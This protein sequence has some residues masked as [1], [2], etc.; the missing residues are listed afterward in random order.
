[1][2]SS[3][4]AL[5]AAGP[6]SRLQFTQFIEDR[7]TPVVD[8]AVHVVP[9]A[10]IN[11]TCRDLLN[12]LAAPFRVKQVWTG[13]SISQAL[14]RAEGQLV[15]QKGHRLLRTDA[16]GS[17]RLSCPTANCLVFAASTSAGRIAAG[18][19]VVWSFLQ[20][21][22]RSR[23]L[24][25]SAG[26]SVVT[27]PPAADPGARELR[28]IAAAALA[29]TLL[30][31]VLLL[32]VLHERRQMRRRSEELLS[33]LRAEAKFEIATLNVAVEAI[34]SIL[35]VIKQGGV[36]GPAV[37]PMLHGTEGEASDQLPSNQQQTETDAVVTPL[38][39][40]ESPTVAAGEITTLLE[41]EQAAMEARR[42]R[43]ALDQSAELFQQALAIQPQAEQVADR[44]E[45]A[46]D[47]ATSLLPI[48]ENRLMELRA[49][50]RSEPSPQVAMEPLPPAVTEG[51]MGSEPPRSDQAE[52][53]KG[54]RL[55]QVLPIA[56]PERNSS[57]D[58]PPS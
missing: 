25:P 53:P 50:R 39:P 58:P 9:C 20:P 16:A 33:T 22:G 36:H 44:L 49:A 5:A 13:A 7:P 15:V 37:P 12:A 45:I 4:L 51:L 40:G 31:A 26:L 3:S 1:M 55:G 2:A 43:L 18:R 48:F 19:T 46:V 8:A 6:V 23:E 52:A 54:T 35:G 27:A 11:A 28:W 29:T 21:L 41:L 24:L 30:L 10:P 56:Q 17:A 42:L 57:S 32:V 38:G 34:H 47:E 14:T